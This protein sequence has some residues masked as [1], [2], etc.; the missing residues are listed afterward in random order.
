M[1]DRDFDAPTSPSDVHID[2]DD[3]N[4]NDDPGAATSRDENTTPPQLKLM[5]LTGAPGIGKS[6]M[7]RALACEMNIEILSWDDSQIEY[8]NTNNNADYYYSDAI[9]GGGHLPYQSRLDSFDTF[10]TQGGAGMTSLDML[11]GGGDDDGDDDGGGEGVAMGGGGHRRRVVVADEENDRKR[12]GRWDGM[13]QNDNMKRRD[14]ERL[15]GKDGLGDGGEKMT[16]ILV[17]EVRHLFYISR[18]Y[19]SNHCT[20]LLLSD[21]LFYVHSSAYLQTYLTCFVSLCTEILFSSLPFSLFFIVTPS[22]I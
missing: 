16:L 3:E 10:L 5:I 7:V 4:D 20:K 11:V 18:P 8:N 9:T 22:E 12:K 14:D 21:R 13:T 2:D 15:R 19:A 17:E 6:A 1:M